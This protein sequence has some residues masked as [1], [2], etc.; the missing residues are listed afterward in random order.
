MRVSSDDQ[1]VNSQKQGV[2]GFAAKKGWAI[3]KY[4]SDEGVSGGK[5]P[6]KRKLG[7]MLKALQKDDVIICSEISR[8]GRDLYMVMDILHFCMEQGV[9]IYTVKDNFVLGDSIQSKVLAFA[10]GLSAE[11]ERQMIRQRTREGLR[12]RMKMGVLLGRPVGR[13]TD[14]EAMKYAEW[15]DRFTQMV[16]WGMMPTQIAKV[17]GCDRNTVN[18]LAARWKLGTKAGFSTEWIKQADQKKKA[19]KSPSYKDGPYKIVSLDMDK[20]L[21]MI[22]EGLTIPEIAERLPEYTYEQV[23][24][25]ILCTE[26][27]N[28]LYRKRAQLKLVKRK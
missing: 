3:E 9:V 16:E 2:D 13:S 21:K 19:N 27:F 22:D 23:Y 15:K 5:D 18:R 25:T 8:L 28:T 11:I 14:E 17:I 20:M 24:D 6:D 12:L 4:I 26:E 1:D 7:P 10:F